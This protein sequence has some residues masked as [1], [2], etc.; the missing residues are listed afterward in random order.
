MRVPRA[1]DR[2]VGDIELVERMPRVRRAE[3]V[4]SDSLLAAM[5]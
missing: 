3:A 1:E 5:R 4:G 2:H